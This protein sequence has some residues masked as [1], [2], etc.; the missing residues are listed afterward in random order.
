MCINLGM[1]PSNISVFGF[2]HYISEYTVVLNVTQLKFVLS[3]TNDIV[4][5]TGRL[6]IDDGSSIHSILYPNEVNIYY[7][8]NAIVPSSA[9]MVISTSTSCDKTIISFITKTITSVH[10]TTHTPVSTVTVGPIVNSN[11]DTIASVVGGVMAVVLIIVIIACTIIVVGS[12]FY[13]ERKGKRQDVNKDHI[14]MNPV[15]YNY[16]YIAKSEQP[17]P[18]EHISANVMPAQT[19][20]VQEEYM[21]VSVPVSTNYTN[22]ST[23]TLER[24]H[25]YSNVDLPLPPLDFRQPLPPIQDVI[26][27]PSPFIAEKENCEELT[28][29]YEEMKP[30]EFSVM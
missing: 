16:H 1:P 30:E 19:F 14:Q 21:E 10:V 6:V 23:T 20:P 28:E 15:N 29:V 8:P 5:I 24:P 27:V 7:N 12:Y 2:R 9:S 11:T 26:G 4:N 13:G 17:V 18:A 25:P 22:L 3:L